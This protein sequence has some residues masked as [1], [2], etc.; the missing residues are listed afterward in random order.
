MTVDLPPFE[1]AHALPAGLQHESEGML[2]GSHPPPPH[3]RVDGD[4]PEREI[5]PGEASDHVIRGEDRGGVDAA[6]EGEGIAKRGRR[7][8]E[9]EAEEEVAQEAVLGPAGGGGG[10]AGEDDDAG[11]GLLDLGEGRAWRE[12]QGCAVGVLEEGRE[13]EEG[14]EFWSAG[15]QEHVTSS[16]TR[17]RFCFGLLKVKKM[18]AVCTKH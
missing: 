2:V 10:V 6:V 16:K 15:G 11:V 5:A 18:E 4:R 14:L 17:R 1:Q 3:R 12:R 9:G 7:R 13:T 8:G